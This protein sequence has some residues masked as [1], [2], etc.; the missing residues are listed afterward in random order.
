R[1]GVLVLR[2]RIGAGLHGELGGERGGGAAVGSWLL[3][4]GSALAVAVG[5][6]FVV[7]RLRAADERDS[8]SGARGGVWQGRRGHGGLAL[9]LRLLRALR[10]E[11]AAACY[12]TTGGP[13]ELVAGA[14]VFGFLWGGPALV[15]REFV[16]RTGR[17]WPAILLL[18]TAAGVVEA[19]LIDQSLFN[20][21]YRDIE[22][23]DELYE[24][25][26]VGN[27]GVS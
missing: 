22:S 4:A 26:H 7:R 8:A 12:D 23:W 11:G 6:P 19:G 17:G 3:V 2:G 27:L 10:A 21:S 9:A 16:R 18:A 13:V 24:P 20:D 5:A 14:V 15:I 1:A 25:T